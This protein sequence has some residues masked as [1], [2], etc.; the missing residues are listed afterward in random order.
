MIFTKPLDFKNKDKNNNFYFKKNCAYYQNISD[1]IC[2]RCKMTICES[3]FKDDDKELYEINIG[4]ENIRL[5]SVQ[6]IMDSQ[7]ICTNHF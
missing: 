2:N 5:N 3:Y 6:N 7:Y 1:K 4:E